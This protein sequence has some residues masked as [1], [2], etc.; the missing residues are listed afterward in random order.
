MIKKT[1]LLIILISIVI[2]DKTIVSSFI[3][4]IY[5]KPIQDANIYTDQNWFLHDIHGFYTCVKT[6]YHIN[7]HSPKYKKSAI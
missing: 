2:A 3:V 7:K 6:S 1:Y 5:N 4:D